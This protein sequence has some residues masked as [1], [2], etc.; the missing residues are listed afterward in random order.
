MQNEQQKGNQVSRN[1]NSRSNVRDEKGD[2]KMNL[3]V[4]GKEVFDVFFNGRRDVRGEEEARGRKR[5]RRLEKLSTSLR[6]P[7]SRLLACSRD[8]IGFY[9][10]KKE[11]PPSLQGNRVQSAR[12]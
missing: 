3:K 4:Y 8:S 5:F 11:T 7:A 10:R 12:S 1:G 2:S 6:E 9:G